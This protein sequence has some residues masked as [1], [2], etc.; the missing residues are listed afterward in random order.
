MS[1]PGPSVPDRGNGEDLGV[2]PS[3]PGLEFL[4]NVTPI[5]WVITVAVTV[6]FF[7]YEFFAH[8]RRPHEPTIG[9][10]ARWSAFYLALALLFGV[11]IGVV[12]GWT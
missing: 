2:D 7:I 11:V 12:S 5:V 8:V 4:V 6:A 1:H 10:S 9:E 3:T